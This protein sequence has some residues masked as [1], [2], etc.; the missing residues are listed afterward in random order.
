MHLW[1]VLKRELKGKDNDYILAD[2][3]YPIYPVV[4]PTRSPQLMLTF[5]WSPTQ[6]RHDPISVTGPCSLCLEC[7]PSRE[8][9]GSLPHLLQS[10]LKG[11]HLNRVHLD[12]LI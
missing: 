6:T 5:L 11:H 1:W 2:L 3:P 10:L 12:R 7:S 9:L 8:P 4:L